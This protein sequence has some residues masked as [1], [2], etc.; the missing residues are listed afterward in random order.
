M[1][2]KQTVKHHQQPTHQHDMSYHKAQNTK[3]IFFQRVSTLLPSLPKKPSCTGIYGGRISHDLLCV[4]L[5]TLRS[6]EAW[7]QLFAPFKTIFQSIKERS[8]CF[9]QH[10]KKCFLFQ[11]QVAF[12]QK[13]CIKHPCSHTVSCT[14]GPRKLDTML[15]HACQELS[16]F[17]PQNYTQ[18]QVRCDRGIAGLS[19]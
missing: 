8:A 3:K 7:D 9:L 19:S 13:I 14:Q 4:V 12:D 6:I 11:N 16:P 5:G 10:K 17:L 15:L 1:V 2:S 18:K